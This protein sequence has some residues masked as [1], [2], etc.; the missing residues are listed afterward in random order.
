MKVIVNLRLFRTSLIAAMLA[1]AGI[2]VPAATVTLAVLP[3]E[4][5]RAPAEVEVAPIEAAPSADPELALV[6]RQ[7]TAAKTALENAADVLAERII[8][9]FT[10]QQLVN[11]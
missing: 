1:L 3:G 8:P 6:E 2:S 10:K 9:R 11:L 5:S 4:G 7:Q